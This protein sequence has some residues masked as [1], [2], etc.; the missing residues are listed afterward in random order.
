MNCGR[1]SDW[2]PT[3]CDGKIVDCKT[4]SEYTFNQCGL[5]GVQCARFNVTGPYEAGGL[6]PA[7]CA[8]C[9]C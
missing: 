3:T 8:A 6:T 9:G 7:D 1:I 2:D 5:D 4:H